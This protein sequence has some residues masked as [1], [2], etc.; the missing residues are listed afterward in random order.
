M[1]N[2]FQRLAGR[3]A[4]VAGPLAWASLVVGLGAADFD[5][6]RLSDAQLLLSLGPDAA[7][8]IRLSFLLSMLGSYL[9]L[10]PLALWLS[11]WLGATSPKLEPPMARM[12]TLAGLGYLALGA[13]GAAILGATS[14]LLL[15]A[16]GQQ[17]EQQPAVLLAFKTARAIAEDGLQGV[18]Q[19]ILGAVWLLGLWR[20]LQRLSRGLGWLTLLLGALLALTALGGLLDVEAIGLAGLTGTILLFPLWSIWA[21]LRALRA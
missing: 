6:E 9:L 12:L 21:G 10:V 15:D 3:L 20:P 2:S 11:D 18:L 19:N 14:A 17:P 16:Y 8:P 4:I 7:Q 13:V 5:F 1:P